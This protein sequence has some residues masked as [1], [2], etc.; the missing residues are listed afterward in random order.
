MDSLEDGKFPSTASSPTTSS[1]SPIKSI[2][3][4][5]VEEE[6]TDTIG[7]N[8]PENP[9]I[10]TNHSTP[11]ENGESIHKN[12][13]AAT[14][15]SDSDDGVDLKNKYIEIKTYEENKSMPVDLIGET[16]LVTK[17]I[18]SQS[19]NKPENFDLLS[20]IDSVTRPDSESKTIVTKTVTTIN[21]D[22]DSHTETTVTE[23]TPS[24][25]S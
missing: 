22:G 5:K 13:D 21:E 16:T 6:E 18:T 20:E 8:I 1:S 19:D 2:P 25:A 15:S 23:T 12:G 7:W 3:E 9:S 17:T 24:E 14:G 4:Q 10:I 11:A